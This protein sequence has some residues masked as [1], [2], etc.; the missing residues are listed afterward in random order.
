MKPQD[1]RIYPN[2]NRNRAYARMDMAAEKNFNLDQA[3]YGLKYARNT[4]RI[5]GTAEM[6]IRILSGYAYAK[7]VIEMMEA[8]ITANT[9]AAFLNQKY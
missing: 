9:A 4:G 7:L 1:I 2:L 3:L 5:T 6:H 8:G